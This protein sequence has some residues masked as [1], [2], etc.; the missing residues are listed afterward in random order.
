MPKRKPTKPKGT[1]LP[2]A[3]S[4]TPA[5]TMPAPNEDIFTAHGG[6]LWQVRVPLNRNND[7][8][9]GRPLH[10]ISDA[11]PGTQYQWMDPQVL[12]P[13]L[14]ADT[15]LQKAVRQALKRQCRPGALQKVQQEV[16]RVFEEAYLPLIIG[17]FDLV[18]PLLAQ[19]ATA[20]EAWRQLHPEDFDDASDIEQ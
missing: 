7:S 8:V 20:R 11:P 13:L 6:R 1:D 15:G 18:A 17:E 5:Y 12:V 10:V 3:L 2:Q 4:P 14:E 19:Y 16:T 9:G